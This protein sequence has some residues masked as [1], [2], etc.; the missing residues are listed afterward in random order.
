MGSAPCCKASVRFRFIRMQNGGCLQAKPL[1]CV[2]PAPPAN[3]ESVLSR[4]FTST[5]GRYSQEASMSSDSGGSAPGRF[6]VL[7]MPLPASAEE[8]WSRINAESVLWAMSSFL[9]S[10]LRAGKTEC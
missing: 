1:G 2:L 5:L 7:K 8:I 10:F 6:L 9:T 3:M 4:R